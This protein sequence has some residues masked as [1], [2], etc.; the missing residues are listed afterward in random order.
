MIS[1]LALLCLPAMAGLRTASD[2]R[3]VASD[4]LH[5]QASRRAPGAQA[6]QLSLAMTAASAD[7][8]DVDYYVFNNSMDR[9]FVIVSGDDLAAPVLGYCDE[10]SFDVNDIPDGLNYMLECYAEQMRY[11]RLHPAAAYVASAGTESMV[12]ITP[13]LT[14]NWNQNSPYN[15][16]CPTFGPEHT[17]AAVGCVATATAQVMNYYKWP[18]QGKGEFTYVCKVGDKEEQ[19]LSAD[20]GSTTYDWDN[21]LDDYIPDSYSEVEGR[22]VATLM[23]HVGI[24]AH[25]EYGKTSTTATFAAMEALREY[26][27]YNQGMRAYVRHC[28]PYAKWDSLIMNELLNARP[29]IYTG[30]TYK[31]GGHCFVLDG[32]NAQGYYHFNWGWGGKSNGYF[33]ITALNPTDQG[34]GSFEGGYNASQEFIANVYPDQGEPAPDRFFEASCL[35]LWAATDHVNLGQKAAINIKHLHFNCFGYG[36]SADI[37]V[38]LVLADLNGKIVQFTSNNTFTRSFDFGSNYNYTD[39]HVF[40]YTTPETIADGNYRLWLAYK[41]VNSDMTGF[42]YLNNIPNLP[43]FINVKV[44]NGVMYF[45]SPITD[46]GKLSVVD[47]IA[48]QEVSAGNKLNLTATVANAGREYFDNVFFALINE[49]DEYT[50]FDPINIDVVTGGQVTFSSIITAP[51]KPGDYMLAV[52]DKDLDIIQGAVTLTVK[53]SGN[54][55]INIASQ[56]QVAN[57]YMDMDNVSATAVLSNS[58]TGDYVGT[59]PF[60]ILTG[61]SKWV[62][63][64]GNTDVV[65]IPAGGTATVNIKTNFEGTPGLVYKMCLRYYKN[66]EKNTIWGDQVPFEVNPIKPTT[67]LDLLL[68]YGEDGKDYAIADNLTVVDTH[69]QSLFATNGRGSWIEIKCGD[70]FDQVAGL[71]AFKAG[72][73]SGKFEKANGNPSIT[74]SMLPEAGVVQSVAAEAIDLNQPFNPVPDMVID[75]SGFYRV[76]DGKPVISAYNGR[77]GETGQL[78]PIAFDWLDALTPITEGKRYDLHGVVL[79]NDAASGAPALKAGTTS[80]GYV[81]YLTKDLVP[82]AS[83]TAV[84]NVNSDAVKIGVTDGVISVTGAHRVAVYNVAGALVG[85]GSEVRLPAGIYIVIA[86]GTMRKVAVR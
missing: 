72:T 38:G 48:P 1:L 17:R 74:L 16:L 11:V 22:A 79:L 25:M 65:T 36:L 12:S 86:D 53:E 78:V 4:F 33:L 18:K 37:T 52:L 43:R 32:I 56:L 6:P 69:D 60:M 27:G 44:Q 3:S 8:R 45:S 80:A 57:Y 15:D 58:G 26:F 7:G 83:G 10:G 62:K 35:R 61:D 46:K 66:P 29:I 85:T 81:V 77:N 49:N 13:L 50:I 39:N 76:V 54:Y 68:S 24:A 30:F 75:F 31:G 71:K 47:L 63:S 84:T 9:G 42:A 2:A 14:T 70:Y 41:V 20:F 23:S 19:T 82:A 55:D 5:S 64:V 59:I 34:I 40:N 21:M 28:V 73:V 51:S 67:L